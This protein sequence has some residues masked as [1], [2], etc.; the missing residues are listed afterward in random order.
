[1]GHRRTQLL[2]GPQPVRPGDCIGQRGTTQLQEVPVAYTQQTSALGRPPSPSRPQRRLCRGADLDRGGPDLHFLSVTGHLGSSQQ[3][4]GSSRLSADAAG[5]QVSE[6]PPRLYTASL[7]PFL[8]PGP[9]TRME[10]AYITG[11]V[12]D[13][14]KLKPLC[15][16]KSACCRPSRTRAIL[17]RIDIIVHN[18]LLQC[19]KTFGLDSH[20]FVGFSSQNES[21]TVHRTQ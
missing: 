6:L 14:I 8:G 11:A 5:T 16:A 7:W 15:G 2:P 1:M 21:G 18:L 3:V 4:D 19:F 12:R 20:H 13:K 10:V 9:G 17:L